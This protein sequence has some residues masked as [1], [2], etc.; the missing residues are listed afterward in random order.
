MKTFE[1]AL[2]TKI[3]D[4]KSKVFAPNQIQAIEIKSEKD[5]NNLPITD[6]KYA[7]ISAILL[8]NRAEDMTP[9]QIQSI[10]LVENNDNAMN[11]YNEIVKRNKNKTPISLLRESHRFGDLTNN[12]LN[13]IPF[14]SDN[15]QEILNYDLE[16]RINISL[17]EMN[18]RRNLN[19]PQLKNYLQT[20]RNKY[21][22]VIEKWTPMF[23][24]EQINSIELDEGDLNNKALIDLF[25]SEERILFNLPSKIFFK[26]FIEHMANLNPEWL[27]KIEIA[28]STESPLIFEIKIDETHSITKEITD[29]QLKSI[30]PEIMKTFEP[31]LI[32]K[33]LDIKSKVFTPAQ[34]QAIEIKSEM[35]QNN[36]PITDN[37]YSQIAAIL[38][39]NRANDITPNQIKNMDLLTKRKGI[40]TKVNQEIIARNENENAISLLRKAH[41]FCDLSVEQL[42]QCIDFGNQDDIKELIACDLLGRITLQLQEPTKIFAETKIERQLNLPLLKGNLESQQYLLM[43]KEWSGMFKFEQLMSCIMELDIKDINGLLNLRHNNLLE[44][45]IITGILLYKYC[46]QPQ[47]TCNEIKKSVEAY[48]DFDIR[49]GLYFFNCIMLATEHVN[50]HS[51]EGK[52]L[53]HEIAKKFFEA[54]DF[55]ELL[56]SQN[57]FSEE[58]FT[59]ANHTLTP[60]EFGFFIW[61]MGVN[62]PDDR[63]NEFL[64]RLKLVAEYHFLGGTYPSDYRNVLQR[65]KFKDVQLNNGSITKEL[66]F[67]K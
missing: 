38:I 27:Q 8:L 58:F 13:H 5:L 30:P 12:Q 64:N 50:S 16:D 62:C 37:E 20:N 32:T 42:N 67:A 45:E 4:I 7:P 14:S 60:D 53:F 10:D 25:S 54:F 46:C 3:L 9:N 65:I 40:E 33:I 48:V 43:I 39:L 2:L 59:F 51:M 15:V 28:G 63:K 6:D 57:K 56:N 26:V 61:E 49:Y 66:V 41:R 18:L 52:I 22:Y 29:E 34:I 1:P 55:W 31:G 11:I 47:I 21:L 24:N 17:C 19:L 36:L 23:S 35:D 44:R